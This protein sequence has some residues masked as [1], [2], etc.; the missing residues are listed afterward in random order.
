MLSTPTNCIWPRLLFLMF[1]FHPF[2]QQCANYYIDLDQNCSLPFN[3]RVGSNFSINI[4]AKAFRYKLLG[5]RFFSRCRGSGSRT[6]FYTKASS[7][8]IHF[9]CSVLVSRSIITAG[10]ELHFMNGDRLGLTCLFYVFFQ[11]ST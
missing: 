4:G 8:A 1:I 11:Q 7:I 3:S 10:I 2:Y 9:S 5:A 6:I